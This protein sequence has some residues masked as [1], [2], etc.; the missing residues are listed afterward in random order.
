MTSDLAPV[1]MQAQAFG[2]WNLVAEIG[3]VLS[4][5]VGGAVRQATGGWTLALAVNAAILAASAGLVVLVR[6]RARDVT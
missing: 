3:A 5:V 2:M 6:E 4:P 1:A